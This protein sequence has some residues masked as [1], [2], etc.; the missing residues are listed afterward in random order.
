MKNFKSVLL[1]LL[2]GTMVCAC[3]SDP[4]LKSDQKLDE[5]D[6]EGVYMALDIQMPTGNLTRSETNENGGSTGGTEIGSAEENAVTTALV[7]LASSADISNDLPE[8]GFIAASEIQSNRI[9]ELTSTTQT[10]AYRAKARLQ[11]TNL[12]ALYERFTAAGLTGQPEVYVFVFVNP[13]KQ[14]TD[15][16][17]EKDLFGTTAWTNLVC[18]V[19]QGE[20][21]TPNQNIGIWGTNSFLM[22]NAQLTTRSLPA[23]VLDW[24]QYNSYDNAFHLSGKNNIG[25]DVVDNETNR[26][27]VNVERSVARFDFKDGSTLGDN[28]YEVL[29]AYTTDG[30]PNNNA[31]V[32]NVQ[33]QKMCLVNMSKSFYYLPRVSPTGMPANSQL[34]GAQIPWERPDGT[35]Q[36]GNYVVGPNAGVFTNTLKTGFSTYFNFAFFE[37]TGAFNNEEMS[38]DRW[39]VVK[40]SD[41]LKGRDD[42]YVGTG[43]T[44]DTADAPAHKAGDYKVWRY[45]T[46][47]VIPG[48]DEQLYG[49]STGV[50][51]KGRLAGPEM[52]T[53]VDYNEAD[54]EKGAYANLA[55]CLN[56]KSFRYNGVEISGLTGSAQHDPILYY[57]N[58]RLY[59]GWRNLRQAAIQDAVTQMVDGHL[60]INRSSSLYKAVFGQGPISPTYKIAYDDESGELKESTKT[61]I[62]INKAGQ[63]VNVVDPQWET[64]KD[65]EEYKSSPDYAWQQWNGEGKDSGE[66]LD[67]PAT[68][69]AFRLAATGAGIAIYQSSVDDQFGPG[70]YCYYYYW[71]RHNDN[72]NNNVMAPMEFAVVRNNVYKLSVDKISRL[73]HPRIPDNDPDN[74]KPSDPDES[75]YVY[76]DVKVAILDWAVRLNSITF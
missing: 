43:N 39:D 20:K 27:A 28:M 33:L 26:G 22:N 51:F 30:Q 74:P 40:I 67:V 76:L 58:G 66:G 48:F 4:A 7:V 54:W 25:D 8:Y 38:A 18:D 65:S 73:G 72:H 21:D 16:F 6:G 2:T 9:N 47:N 15:F 45:V 24:E 12:N 29:Y 41:V 69:T 57:I 11:K 64:L 5:R 32:V 52:K 49:I 42:N 1:S 34:C 23:N 70:Y 68:L 62:F 71:N 60:E 46:E 31:P 14:L 61:T 53:G 19:I 3:A 35:W 63:Q 75:D 10:T 56:G 50:V 13:T 55:N 44:E 37:D 17:A 36:N 59:M